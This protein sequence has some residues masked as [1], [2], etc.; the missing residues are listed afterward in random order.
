MDVGQRVAGCAVR[1]ISRLGRFFEKLSENQMYANLG[2][3]LT[4]ELWRTVKAN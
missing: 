4:Y 3:I 1:V 2:Y